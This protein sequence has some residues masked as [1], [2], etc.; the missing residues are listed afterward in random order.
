MGNEGVD[1]DFKALFWFA[2]MPQNIKH[3]CPS[4]GLSLLQIRWRFE[5]NSEILVHILNKKAPTH[6]N[7]LQEVVLTRYHTVKFYGEY[8]QISL[9]LSL[10]PYLIQRNEQPQKAGKRIRDTK[11]YDME[12]RERT[13]ISSI[14]EPLPLLYGALYT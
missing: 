5:D 2:S 14:I 9:S 4:F 1:D 10:L 13:L 8:V 6:Q 11:F 3:C 12:K 7:C